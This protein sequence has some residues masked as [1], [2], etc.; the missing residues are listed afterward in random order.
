[1]FKKRKDNHNKVTGRKRKI[2]A[3]IAL[4][5]SLL[6]AKTRLSFSQSSSPNF[7]NQEVSERLID[8]REF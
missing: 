5:L 7:S 1:M 3:T 4:S 2:F 6:F 8:N